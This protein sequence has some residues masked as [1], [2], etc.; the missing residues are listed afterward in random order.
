VSKIF[1][2]VVG[3]GAANLDTSIA[4]MSPPMNGLMRAVP[5]SGLGSFTRNSTL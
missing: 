3:P 1:S 5:E 2:Q 4:E